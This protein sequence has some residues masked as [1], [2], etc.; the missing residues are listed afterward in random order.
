MDGNGKVNYDDICYEIHKKKNK[1]KL[2]IKVNKEYL[3]SNKYP[4]TIDPTAWWMNDKLSTAMVLNINGL[5]NENLHSQILSVENKWRYNTNGSGIEQRVYL[6]TESISTGDS[7]VTQPMDSRTDIYDKYIQCA[8]LK[9]VENEETYYS[10][11]DCGTIEIRTPKSEWD[12]QQIT[13]NTQPEISDKVWAE[14]QCTGKKG[15]EHSVDLTDWAQGI[16]DGTM[17][18][19]GLV[20]LAKEEKT[21]DVFY[22]PEFQYA[23]DENGNYR[24]PLYMRLEIIYGDCGLVEYDCENKI[25]RRYSYDY[26]DSLSEPFYWGYIP[27]KLTVQ[28]NLIQPFT[29]YPGDTLEEVNENLYPYTAIVRLRSTFQS[30]K[31]HKFYYSCGT[32]FVIGPNTIVTAGHCMRGGVDKWQ[33]DTKV[34]IEDINTISK[35][36]VKSII[37]PVEYCEGALS[38][39]DWAILTV[40]GNIGEETGWFGFGIP[41]NEMIES[42]ITVAGYT[43]ANSNQ[44]CKLYKKTGKIK[45]IS[46]RNVYY[47]IST[48]SGQ[49]GG[50]VFTSDNIVWAIHTFG[51]GTDVNSNN[52]GSRINKCIFNLLYEKRKEGIEIYNL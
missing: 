1:V 22:G 24:I 14:I 33:Y 44:E 20:F 45:N 46:E 3:K 15:T 23:Q 5:E 4:I 9:I 31:D 25:E 6:D 35:Y 43:S 30:E 10:G 42:D 17:E 12:A 2:T 48:N 28:N 18:N 11:V 50:P 21:R 41:N 47:H 37:C 40:D 19:T 36:S 29:I 13:W 27:V 7:F 52:F 49:S 34:Y 38:E 8:T 16:A 26:S 32:G 39:F 51:G